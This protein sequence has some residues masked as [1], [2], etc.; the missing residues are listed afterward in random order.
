MWD[1]ELSPKKI[2][3]V[4]KPWIGPFVI[5]ENLGRV[6]NEIRS[7]IDSKIA[8]VQVNRL[9]R[10]GLLPVETG[11]R[12]GGV[13]PDIMRSLKKIIAAENRFNKETGENERWFKVQIGG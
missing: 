6:E 10:I 12:V 11:N 7:E 5:V 2:S 1:K 9:Q 13:F 3:K 8:R 4:I